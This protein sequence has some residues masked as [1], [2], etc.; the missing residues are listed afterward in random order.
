[1]KMKVV[2]DL[3]AYEQPHYFKLKNKEFVYVHITVAKKGEDEYIQMN[4][5]VFTAKEWFDIL[6]TQTLIKTEN[7]ALNIMVGDYYA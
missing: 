4:H 3:V 7:V 5:Q 1:M 6:K 2:Y